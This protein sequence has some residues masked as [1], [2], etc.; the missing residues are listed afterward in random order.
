MATT[1]VLAPPPATA[2][3]KPDTRASVAALAAALEPAGVD[4]VE[5]LAWQ[6]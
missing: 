5:P 3:T 2:P 6:W 4:V 1:T